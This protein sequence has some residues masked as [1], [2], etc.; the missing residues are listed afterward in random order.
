MLV[1]KYGS[2]DDFLKTYNPSYQMQ[3]CSNAE[4]CMFGDYPTLSELRTAYGDNVPKMWLL[5]Q[6]YDLSEYC[7]VKDKLEGTPL[8]ETAFV[9][10]TEYYYMKVT[11]LMLFFHRFK[12]GRY[13]R[14]YGN[15]D[16]LVITTSLREF[17]RERT[18][19]IERKESDLMR[20]K[21]EESMKGAVTY[22]EYCRMKKQN[23]L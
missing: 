17:N 6:L 20:K 15:V 22:E 19:A 5:P 16:P 10:A 1:S 23:Q 8:E 9:I 14:F 21:R 11:E 3:K 2:R 18:A 13:G 4:D 7:G 12:A